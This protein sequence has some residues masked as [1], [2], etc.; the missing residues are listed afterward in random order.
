[1]RADDFKP[2]G[3]EYDRMAQAEI[4]HYNQVYLEDRTEQGETARATLQQPVPRSWIEM[5]SRSAALIRA[6]TG[7][8]LRGHMAARLRRAP[9]VRMLSLGSG[10]GGIELILA[11]QAPEAIITCL[12][13][14]P[15]L[16]RLGQERAEREGLPVRFEVGD[17]NRVDLPRA[18]FDIVF[19]HASLHHVIELERLAGQIRGALAD[20]GELLTLDI[21]TPNGY[22]MRD[23]TREVVRPLFRSLP[24]RF[25]VNHTAYAAPKLDN[26]IWE[27]DTSQGSMECIRS[28]DI[29]PVL[30]RTFETRLYVPYF[31]ICRRF[32]DTMYGPN[33]DLARPLDM[34]LLNWIWELDRHYIESGELQPETFFGV[35]AR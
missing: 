14:N 31:S 26:E 17:L 10:P 13:L 4:A 27:M 25:R 1:M 23:R 15:D 30:A 24:D 33:Y 22:L 35:Y 29:V 20:G 34:A 21:S 7:A 16:A 6:K 3:S 28:E 19:C 9:G 5:E 12:D 2:G 11:R 32:L 18:E 8:D